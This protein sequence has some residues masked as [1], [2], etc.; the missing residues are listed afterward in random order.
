VSLVITRLIGGLGNQ[1]FQYA[2]GRAIALRRD[3]VLKL[4]ITGF[5]AVGTHTRRRYELDV[6]SIHASAAS[7]A[8]LAQF[9]RT[10]KPRSPRLDRLLGRLGIGRLNGDGMTYR[11]PHFHYDPK[12]AKLPVPVYLDGYWQSEK[13]FSD[14]GG[15]LR[16]EFAAKVPVDREN[17][18]LG[19]KIDA[20]NA[21]SLHVRRGDYITNPA[22]NRFHGVCSPDY[23]QGAVDYIVGRA[24][25]PHLFV[26]SDDR[27]W[28]C[29]NMRFSVPTT[30]VDLN[31]PDCGYRDMQLMARCRHHIAANSSFSW[32]GAWLNPS[33]EKIVV[34]PKHWFR[35]SRNDARDLIPPNWVKL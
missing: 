31:P 27:E 26:F 7:A 28:T 24:A 13:Y 12:V 35:D 18:I 3:A 15:M 34:V 20:V 6:L 30:F 4:D 9:G 29:A 21:V 16:Q 8:D 19:A 23:Y 22:T 10:G 33:T 25:R 1:M 2:A 5:G 11:E 17:E 14:I 32:W